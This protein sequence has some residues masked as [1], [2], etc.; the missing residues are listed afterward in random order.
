MTQILSIKEIW[1]IDDRTL[2]IT[3]TDH[4]SQTFDVVMLRRK[5]PCAKCIDEHTGE[6]IL[7]DED[8]S[9]E[10]R[11][12][13]IDSVGRYALSIEFDDGHNTGIYTFEMLKKI[14]TNVE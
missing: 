8:I 5:C 14:G 13:K 2:G 7:K 6:K 1:Q 11:P 9:D 12:V 4:S 3:W 10:L